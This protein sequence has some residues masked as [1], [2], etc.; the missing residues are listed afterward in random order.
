MTGFSESP[1]LEPTREDLQWFDLIPWLFP[2]FFSQNQDNHPVIPRDEMDSNSYRQMHP[3]SASNDLLVGGWTNPS[4][5][6][7]QNGFIFPK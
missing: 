2:M 3:H 4:K 6:I 5:Q 7:S 1:W